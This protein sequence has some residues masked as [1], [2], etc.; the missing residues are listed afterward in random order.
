MSTLSRQSTRATSAQEDSSATV[1]VASALIAAGVT[2]AYKSSRGRGRRAVS[3]LPKG[4]ADVRGSD[5][6]E[7]TNE[8][9]TKGM[10][11]FPPFSYVA[12]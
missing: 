9:V 10:E 8:V 7:H 2:L 6:P 11:Y 1:V 12:V 3:G 5:E 4:F